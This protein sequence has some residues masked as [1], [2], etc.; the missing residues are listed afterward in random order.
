M[1]N[2]DGGPVYVCVTCV[3]SVISLTIAPV[4]GKLK[5]NTAYERVGY[6]LQHTICHAAL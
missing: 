4:S 5:L 3:T 6:M 1:L 2:E